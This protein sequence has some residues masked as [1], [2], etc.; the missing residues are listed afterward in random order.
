LSE[1]PRTLLV[2][3]QARAAAAA[4][5]KR[6]RRR[7]ATRADRLEAARVCVL[8]NAPLDALGL[9]Q[10][11]VLSPSGPRAD[12]WP[13]ERITFALA[14]ADRGAL[15]QAVRL[16]SAPALR[17]ESVAYLA[18]A[19]FRALRFDWIPS[20]ELRR[21]K[22]RHPDLSARLRAVLLNRVASAQAFGERDPRAAARTMEEAA[23]L[24]PEI[25][26]AHEQDHV[27]RENAQLEVQLS[28]LLRDQERFRRTLAAL[29]EA[30]GPEPSSLYRD[31]VSALEAI[32]GLAFGTRG[33]KRAALRG[34]E[35]A[36]GRLREAGHWE[37][38][39]SVD[40]HVA[41]LTDEPEAWCRLYFGTPFA[42]ARRWI[43]EATRGRVEIP[44]VHRLALGGPGGGDDAA[45]DDLVP[46]D[47]SVTRRALEG[48][49]NE[50]YRTPDA[51]ALHETIYPGE[52]FNLSSSPVRVRQVLKRLRA[53][54]RKSRFPVDVRAVKGGYALVG[55]R[56][57]AILVPRDGGAAFEGPPPAEL[58]HR[59]LALWRRL[60]PLFAEQE[61][62]KAAELARR[63]EVS[64]P[65]LSRV[66]QG[67]EKAG[68]VLREGRARHTVYR[69]ARS[70]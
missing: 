1:D 5:L 31:W 63:L 15:E 16:L 10:R 61:R 19:R 69:R 70:R 8:A 9:L 60:V 55:L 65:T 7:G 45:L 30:A 13:E 56:P 41:L 2:R 35:R 22:D 68:W 23:A 28:I 53:E 37:R 44:A 43:L 54:L 36:R 64:Q 66:L 50:R 32:G 38:L 27:R 47:G 20:E 29:R 34:L 21:F 25:R 52:Y 57:C 4:A 59:G 46:S 62:W 33:E 3:G 18:L 40:F 48:L 42:S 11:Q 58:T 67:A 39:R 17:D 12:V 49:V 14:L 26:P 24:V 6:A 51:V